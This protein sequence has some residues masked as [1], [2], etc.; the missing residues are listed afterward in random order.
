MNVKKPEWGTVT[1]EG[2]KSTQ[3]K[4]IRYRDAWVVFGGVRCPE[5]TD[6]SWKTLITRERIAQLQDFVD[7]Y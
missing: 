4:W 7:E 6:T 2:I 5:I 3:R 1:K